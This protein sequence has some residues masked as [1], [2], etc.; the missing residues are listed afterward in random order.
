MPVTTFFST[1]L[2][3]IIPLPSFVQQKMPISSLIRTAHSI[4]QTSTG[5]LSENK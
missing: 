5:T 1:P 4:S 3:R 2:A